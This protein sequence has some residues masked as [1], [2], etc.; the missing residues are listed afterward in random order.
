MILNG[1]TY[2][3][4][5]VW[6]RVWHLEDEEYMIS[7]NQLKKEK[8]QVLE[9]PYYLTWWV[10]SDVSRS[11]IMQCEIM[12]RLVCDSSLLKAHHVK[13]RGTSHASRMCDK[14]DLGIEETARHIIMQ[15]PFF[16]EDK[17]SLT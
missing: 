8:F 13:S 3:K 7:K 4:K 15:C 16:E 14:C 9:K 6:E 11:N 2:S 10:M 1:H 17:K 5:I 12:A